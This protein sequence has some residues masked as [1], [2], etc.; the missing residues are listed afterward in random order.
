MKAGI[1]HEF[2]GDQTVTLNSLKMKSELDD[3]RLY[4][5]IG[6][7]WQALENMRLYLQAEKEHGDHFSRDYNISAG[8]KWQF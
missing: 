1:T 6:V 4:A 3:T 8:L 5:G 2:L 7:D